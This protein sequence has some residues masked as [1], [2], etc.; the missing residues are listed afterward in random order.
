M[1]THKIEITENEL[2]AL[3]ALL[4]SNLI[5]FDGSKIPEDQR[6][7]YEAISQLAEKLDVK[8]L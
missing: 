2:T 6:P 5:D 7:Y 4:I 3:R 8:K 1:K